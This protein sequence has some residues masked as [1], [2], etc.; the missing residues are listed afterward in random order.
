MCKY[1]EINANIFFSS[2]ANLKCIPSDGQMYPRLGT[3]A[4]I[5]QFAQFVTSFHPSEAFCS[6]NTSFAVSLLMSK[7]LVRLR[8]ETNWGSLSEN[9]CTSQ[10]AFLIYTRGA[11]RDPTP[12]WENAESLKFKDFKG[13]WLN[14]GVQ[15]EQRNYLLYSTITS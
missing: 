5:R 2:I 10:F 1:L 8:I 4:L 7:Q 3:S 15:I 11:K 9:C 12:R 13:V 14:G 6:A